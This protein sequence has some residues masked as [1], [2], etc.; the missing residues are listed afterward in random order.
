MEYTIFPDSGASGGVSGRVQCSRCKSFCDGDMVSSSSVD[1]IVHTVC[2]L[3]TTRESV[4]G[5]VPPGSTSSQGKVEKVR[6]GTCGFMVNPV[7]HEQR[8]Q[9]RDQHSQEATARMRRMAWL[10]D[11]THT[12]DVRVF[13]LCSG[14]AFKDLQTEAQSYVEASAQADFYVSAESSKERALGVSTK[15]LSTAFEASYRGAFR[16]EYV[17]KRLPL[18]L[19]ASLSTDLSGFV[20]PGSRYHI[21]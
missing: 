7:G 16:Y 6:C 12:A 5:Q 3:C 15:Q 2:F 14:V 1:G 13:L 20:Q 4:Y 17:S 19:T 10:G 18:L 8:C 9:L 21:F 11:A